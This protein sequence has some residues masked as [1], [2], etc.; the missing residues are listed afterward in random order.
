MI[1]VIFSEAKFLIVDDQMQNV[2]LLERFLKRAGYHQI[3]S[4]VDPGKF[5]NIYHTFQPDI[6]LMDLHMPE[7][8]GFDLLYALQGIIP[9][10]EYIPILVLTADTSPDAKRKA[11]SAGAKDFISKPL[12]RTEVL[13]RINNLLETRRLHLKIQAHNYNLEQKVVERTKKLEEAQLEILECM[14]KAT[15]FRDDN[16]GEH[17]QRVGEWSARL[18]QSLGMDLSATE[19]LRLA[20]PLHDVGKIGIPDSILLKPG[21]LTKEEFEI[22]KS[23]TWIGREILSRSQF[24]VFQMAG[25]ISLSH[26]ECWNGSG[27]PFGLQGND[28]PLVGQ[29]VSIVDVFDALTHH[30]PYKSAWSI[31]EA[32]DEIQRLKGIKFSPNVVDSFVDLLTHA[33]SHQRKLLL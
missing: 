20:A 15:E 25:E 1:N 13:L 30:R 8:D 26:H 14:A 2:E 17:T 5:L 9:K 23:H 28:I 11:L 21:K 16:T 22:V 19:M 31:E 3:L 12:D 32:L 18:A 24:P 4:T 27:Y 29:I 7:L 6:I 33:S 10:D